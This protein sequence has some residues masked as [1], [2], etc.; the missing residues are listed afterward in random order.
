[1]VVIGKP[2]VRDKKNNVT[3]TLVVKLI[4]NLGIDLAIT[5]QRYILLCFFMTFCKTS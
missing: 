4:F 5:K 3:F 1:M 2:T